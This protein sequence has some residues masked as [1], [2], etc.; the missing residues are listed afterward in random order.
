M[1]TGKKFLT[2]A[3]FLAVSFGITGCL[4]D[5]EVE[6]T[7]QV[8]AQKLADS[9]VY[10][11]ARNGLCFGVTTTSRVATSGSAAVSNMMVNVPCEKVNL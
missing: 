3:V 5:P 6:K 9:L 8:H 10:V 7:T 2:L 1:S 4:F 11:K